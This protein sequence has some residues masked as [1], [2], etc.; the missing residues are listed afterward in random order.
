[1]LIETN[2]K[3]VIMDAGFWHERWEANEIAFHES[4]G[5]GLLNA[6]FRDRFPQTETRVFV[7]LCGKMLD[8][9]WLLAQGYRVVGA[10]LSALAIDQ[11]FVELGVE[12][13][14]EKDGNGAWYRA[15]GIDI[16]VGDIFDL[17]AETLGTV[18]CVYD[19]AALVALPQDM[20]VRYAAH[21]VSIT[22]GAPQFLI[23]FD[24]DQNIM[25]GPPFSIPEDAVRRLYSD[26][27][28]I[29][30][31]EARSVEGGL[32]GKAPASECAWMLT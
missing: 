9:A 26:A 20:R 31:I 13:A 7:P 2:A 8:I 27:Y 24:Y 21:I 18:D 32:K 22:G 29:G 14:I 23:C 5:N 12:P 17:T 6:H 16:Y 25:P 19:R 30:P 15:D 1:M 28:E 4:A 10:E 11:L 3:D